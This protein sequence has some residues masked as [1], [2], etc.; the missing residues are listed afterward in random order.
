M[1]Q[2]TFGLIILA[3]AVYLLP[4]C[5][6]YLT[7]QPEDRLTES[8]VY[9]NEKSIQQALNGLYGVIAQNGLYGAGLTCKTVDMLGQRYNTVNAGS[10]NNYQQIQTFAYTQEPVMNTFD[11]LWQNGYAAI[12]GTNKFIAEMDG[13]VQRGVITKDHGDQMKGEAIGMRAM[14]HFDLLRL[15]GPVYLTSPDA[16]AI[17]YY[18]IADGRTRPIIPA[19]A[20]MDS[21]LADLS[22][23]ETLLAKDPVI[24]GGVIV[25]TNFYSGYRNQRLNYYAV[26][27]LIARAQLYAGNKPAANAAAKAVLDGGEKWFPWVLRAAVADPTSPDRI[28]YPEVL[29]AVYNQDMYSN[30]NGLFSVNVRP[31]EI[32]NALPGRLDNIYESNANDYRNQFIWPMEK[33]RTFNKFADAVDPAKPWRFLQPLVRKTELY[34]ILAETGTDATIQRG[35]LDSVRAHRGLTVLPANAVI[36]T[37]VTKEYQKEFFGEGQ[38]FF[39]FKRLNQKPIP[40]G[41]SATGT[42]TPNYIVPLPLSET[43]PR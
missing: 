6:K 3:A 9:T 30:F 37:E 42:I 32:L 24:T 10:S 13:A 4:G 21:V 23:A 12:L 8:Q 40:S 2:R 16:L 31:T 14:L 34:Y 29:F 20:V 25:S 19:R 28:F 41:T 5:K 11:S 1:T 38:M 18:R 33:G 27:A 7:V 43:T 15:F 17:P 39:Y 22:A 36:A 26:K 35:Y